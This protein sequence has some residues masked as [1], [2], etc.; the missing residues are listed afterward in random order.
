MALAGG[1]V[2][3]TTFAFGHGT[4]NA[5]DFGVS[6]GVAAASVVAYLVSH[7]R[8]ER[9]TALVSYL[10]A[11][12]S[13]LVTA[14]VF[15]GATQRWLTFAAAAAIVGLSVAGQV[16]DLLARERPAVRPVAK[17]QAA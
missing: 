15:S 3:V 9:A 10:V 6:I 1:F 11:A 16:I 14:G 5:I 2:V 7:S 4:A 8:L 12:W 17:P 13:I